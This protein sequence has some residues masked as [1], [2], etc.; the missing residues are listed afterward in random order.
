MKP[1]CYRR[2]L[3]LTLADMAL[4]VGLSGKNPAHVWSRYEKGQTGCPVPLQLHVEQ[5]TEGAIT[6]HDWAHVRND[7][8]NS[9]VRAA[10]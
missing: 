5:L 10:E 6:P 8:L 1:Y 4:K 2:D 3:N 9:K 7:Y